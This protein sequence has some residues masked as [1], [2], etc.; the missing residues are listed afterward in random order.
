MIDKIFLARFACKTVDH[1][2][3]DNRLIL[4]LRGAGVDQGS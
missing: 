3:D 2:I 1:F 4:R